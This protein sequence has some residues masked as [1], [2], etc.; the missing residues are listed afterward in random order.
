MEEKQKKKSRKSRQ[1]SDKV[2]RHHDSAYGG[3]SIDHYA[4]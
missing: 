2:I 1:Y 4:G 3:V